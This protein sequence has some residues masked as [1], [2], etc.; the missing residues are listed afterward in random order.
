LD[1]LRR[2]REW[3]PDAVSAAR[4]PAAALRAL[5]ILIDARRIAKTDRAKGEERYREAI[6]VAPGWFR[7]RAFLAMVLH[8]AKRHEEALVEWRAA[9]HLAPRS[10]STQLG[11]AQTLI[12]L[13]Y[14]DQ[15][16]EIWEKL[17]VV[18]PDRPEAFSELA[19]LAYA[20]GEIEKAARHLER[21][22]ELIPDDPLIARKYAAAIANVGDDRALQVL[23]RALGKG[24]ASAEVLSAMAEVERVVHPYK[25]SLGWWSAELMWPDRLRSESLARGKS[26]SLPPL[27][28]GRKTR[29]LFATRKNWSFMQPIVEDFAKRPAY[30]VRT[31]E[32][33]DYA[34]TGLN[35]LDDPS[36]HYRRFREKHPMDARLV[37]HADIVFCEWC[38]DP[39]IWL[40]RCLPPQKRLVIRFHSSEAYGPWPALVDWG[41]VDGLIFVADHVR[42]HVVS[43]L[44]LEAFTKLRIATI[45]QPF[46]TGPFDRPKL[47]GAEH[48]LAMI[49]Y[50]DRNKDPKLAIEILRALSKK[51]D[52]WRL[53]MLGHPFDPSAGHLVKRSYALSFPRFLDESGVKDKITFDNWTHDV[54]AWLQGAG[55]I[56]STSEREGTH[57]AVAEGMAS[58]AIPIVRDWPEVKHLGGARRRYPN[59]LFFDTAEAA[60]ELIASAAPELGPRA[61]AE[62]RDRFDVA[63]VLPR[64]EALLC[65]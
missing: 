7:P 63:Q 38:T 61:K 19:S 20:N 35:V 27:P 4:H 62:A 40:S 14:K 34:V 11:L 9:A 5:P 41:R 12:A 23:R 46:D 45:P 28:S 1:R 57:E 42:D 33:E 59:A 32:L 6:R 29:L 24:P 30:E 60:A 21:A 58:G 39:A 10:Y 25:D 65:D 3:I 31:L 13:G 22:N 49:G 64:L 18:R 54:A 48:T 50:N 53:K 8:R 55:F 43:T 52:R 51:D 2:L 44:G 56:L 26:R 36:G 15:A 37:E 47:A 17:I 16:A